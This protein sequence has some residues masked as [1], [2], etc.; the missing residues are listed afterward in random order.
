MVENHLFIIWEKAQHQ[1]DEILKDISE[2]FEIVGR[3]QMAWSERLFSSNLSR[4]YGQHLPPH[5]DKELHCGKGPFQLILVR[6]HQPHYAVRQTSRGNE[7]VNTRMFDAKQRYRAW[8]GGGHRI[9]GTNSTLETIHDSILLLGVDAE[10]YFE[11]TTGAADRLVDLS[12]HELL[13]AEGWESIT[14]LFDT[15]N[16]LA[17]YVVLRNFEQLPERFF[18]DSHDDID[19]LVRDRDLVVAILNAQRVFP[20]PYRTHYHVTIEG[21]KVPFDIRFVGDKYYSRAFEESILGSRIL[22]RGAF[23]RPDNELYFYSLIYHALV[24]K[25]AMKEDYRVRL[26]AMAQSLSDMPASLPKSDR[27]FAVLLADFLR[28]R[29]L[30]IPRPVDRSVYYNETHVGQLLGFPV[31]VRNS[32]ERKVLPLSRLDD[33][34]A[35]LNSQNLIYTS[36]PTSHSGVLELLVHAQ[37]YSKLIEILEFAGGAGSDSEHRLIFQ[38]ENGL[39]KEILVVVHIAGDGYLPELFAHRILE[40]RLSDGA[41]YCLMAKDAFLALLYHAVFHDGVIRFPFSAKLEALA[42][43]AGVQYD[44]DVLGN[45]RETCALLDANE[46]STAMPARV[47][48]T[49]QLPYLAHPRHVLSSR[50]LT[51]FEDKIYLSRV[52]LMKT[53]EQQWIRKQTSYDLA[54]REYHFLSQLESDY[55]P[56]VLAFQEEFGYTV[57]DLEYIDGEP[58]TVPFASDESPEKVSEFIQ[59]CI[60]ILELLIQ[61]GISHRD[62]RLANMKLRNGTPVLLD[63]GWATSAER[64]YG[65]PHLLGGEALPPDEIPCDFYGMGVLLRFMC[66]LHPEFCHVI[67]AMTHSDR[68]KRITS[69]SELRHM[70]IGEEPSPDAFE[71]ACLKAI[72]RFMDSAHW[73]EAEELLKKLPADRPETLN[74]RGE[75]AFKCERYEEACGFFEAALV[76]DGDNS[77]ARYNLAMSLFAAG[78]LGAAVVQLET[79][80]AKYP[81][82][83]MA[84]NDLGVINFQ[85]GALDRA[86][87]YLERA[88]ALDPTNELVRQNLADVISN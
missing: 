49:Q 10:R 62:V 20:E 15:L 46:V 21:K 61:R 56:R 22:Q 29:G 71:A 45:F 86:R 55:F 66:G 58:L 17:D 53:D 79:L 75:I 60:N 27:D 13:A 40:R 32:G 26:Q 5:S 77:P 34:F 24:H 48:V 57:V 85:V 82:H 87:M 1:A 9:H 3:Y 64:P 65:A 12:G 67:D 83:A 74:A 23:Y 50:L 38:G 88:V 68:Q 7:T 37:H 35:R 73:A 81:D 4:F 36:L 31:D 80:V 51:T 59:H 30:S 63:F 84:H 11:T 2:N 70:L 43:L 8:T 25:P 28:Q 19:L 18:M 78:D 39:Q 16:A 14:D 41:A 69:V 72:S 47:S 76:I 6:D 54:E 33:L 52:Y 42:P 44:L